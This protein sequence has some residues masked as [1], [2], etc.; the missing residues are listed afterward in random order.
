MI[1]KTE[2]F[3]RLNGGKL[4]PPNMEEKTVEIVRDSEGQELM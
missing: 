2:K 4:D 1:M 3:F